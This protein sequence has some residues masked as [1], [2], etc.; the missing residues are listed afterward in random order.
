MRGYSARDVAEMLG[1]SVAQV[2][3]YARSGLLHPERGPRGEY[4][5][6]FQDLV[7]LQAAS[8]LVAARIPAHKVRRALRHLREQLPGG[9]PLTGV[10][11][12]AVGDTIVVR[13][14]STLW[15]PDSGQVLFDFDVADLAT[16]VAP[17]ARRVAEAAREVEDELDAEDWYELAYDLEAVE[18]VQARDA[19]RRA[20][21]LDPAHADARINLGR[22]LHEAGQPAAAEAHYRMALEAQPGDATAAFNL[23]VAL[24]DLGRRDEAMSA[25]ETALRSDPSYADAHYNLACLLERAGKA[26]AALR[27]L[28]A[29]R[30][31]VQSR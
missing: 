10:R 1:L 27:H 24:E 15:N 5:F 23:G 4:R 11:I 26:T 18:P 6:T 25:Y 7:L 14:G 20:L 17:F 2:R 29:Y 12:A 9:R 16:Q 21:E 19:Y 8:R 28:K 3:G 30:K 22:L 13:D 31:I